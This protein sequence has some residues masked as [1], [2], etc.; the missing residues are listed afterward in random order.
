M[1][2]LHGNVYISREWLKH[3]HVFVL[4]DRK[5]GLGMSITKQ[6]HP[7]A[8]IPVLPYPMTRFLVPKKLKSQSVLTKQCGVVPGA[9]DRWHHLIL[10]SLYELNPGEMSVH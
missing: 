10:Q 5:L 7:A 6:R 4:W 3:I 8:M 9:V 1:H 2:R